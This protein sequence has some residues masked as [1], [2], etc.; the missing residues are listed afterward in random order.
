MSLLLSLVV[1]SKQGIRQVHKHSRSVS[2]PLMTPHA[3]LANTS[4]FE[5][6]REGE[7]LAGK[8]K[9]SLAGAAGA[10]GDAATFK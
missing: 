10:A 5:T 8:T 1:L 7:T 4:Q 3:S 6:K 9:S 2:L